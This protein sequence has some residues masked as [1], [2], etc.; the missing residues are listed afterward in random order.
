MAKTI[1]FITSCCFSD[2]EANGKTL[3]DLFSFYPKENI[4]QFF[5]KSF[6][7]D[8]DYCD[9]Y[10]RVTDKDMLRCFFKHSGGELSR[11]IERVLRASPRNGNRIKK[12]AFRLSI[13][14]LIWNSNVW[15]HRTGFRRWIKKVNPAVVLY[16]VGENPFM[17]NIAIKVSKWQNIPLVVFNTEGY[18]FAEKNYFAESSLLG[19]ICFPFY[20]LAYKR[21]FEKLMAHTA[22][23]FYSC[24]KLQ[25]DYGKLFNLPSEVLYTSSKISV[26]ECVAKEKT[27]DLVVSYLGTLAL[28]RQ[29]PL[30]EIG[31]AIHDFNQNMKLRVFGRADDRVVD[32]LQSSPGIDYQ[33]PIPYQ[34]VIKEIEDSDILVH[35]ESNASLY[36]DMIKYGFTTKIA[37]SLMGGRCF[38]VYAPEYVA[39]YDYIKAINPECVA[40]NEQEMKERL[41]LLLRNS[42]L[43]MKCIE[44][45]K[46]YAQK[47]HHPSVNEQKINRIVASVTQ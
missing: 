10:F 31:N 17:M 42:E 9:N 34:Q 1:L 27:E 8:W 37:D 11:P 40:S 32:E 6:Q 22:H 25:N 15:M 38:F 47:N 2:Y 36:Q 39:C 18:Y 41:V 3:E 30:I 14:Q 5:V 33:G 24:P 12:D 45:F 35:A 28:G 43:R 13:R 16:M 29:K 26:R 4:A 20:K 44:R 21:S 19:S 7:P 23:V 46:E